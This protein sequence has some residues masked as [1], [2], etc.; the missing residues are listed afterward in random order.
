MIDSGPWPDVRLIERLA[1]GNRNDVWLGRLGDGKV[2]VRR[3][4]RPPESLAWE[5]D[6]M[7]Q[8]GRAE[9][10]VPSIVLTEDGRRSVDGVVVQLW[11]E[12]REPSSEADWQL[13]AN[14]FVRLHRKTA[15][16]DQRPG[17][18]TVRELRSVRRCV[19]V[20]LGMMPVEA[21]DRILAVFEGLTEVPVAVVHGDPGPS[22]IRLG[23][24]GAVGLMDWDESRMDLTW[25]DLSNL[26]VQVLDDE[27]HQLALR[28]SDAWEAANGWVTEPEYARRRLRTLHRSVMPAGVE[29]RVGSPLIGPGRGDRDRR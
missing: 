22:N 3:S 5:L 14:E 27:S 1:S 4:R 28:L 24:D 13:V 6:L 21:V 18:C 19:D 12:G 8:L 9:F 10:S 25:H 11:L 26:G 23:R 29:G 17:C 7:D 20:D 16:H 2:A 15:G